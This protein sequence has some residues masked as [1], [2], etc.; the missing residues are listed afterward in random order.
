MEKKIEYIVFCGLLVLAVAAGCKKPFS[1]SL[2]ATANNYLVVEGVINS[3][4]DSTIIKLSRTVS[5]SSSMPVHAVLHAVV[6]VESDQNKSYNLTE[7]DNGR[8]VFAGL[9][10]DSTRKYRLH[11]TDGGNKEYLSDFV[12]VVN[13]PPIDTV[14]YTV[15]KDGVQI[16]TG[17]HDPK[18]ATRYY[19]WSF[20]ETWV[21]H[22]RFQSVSISDGYTVTNRPYDQNIYKCWGNDASST[23]ILGSSAKLTQDVITDKPITFV[24]AS[25]EKFTDKYS[26][27]VKQYGLTKEA[28]NFWQDLK[29]NTEQLGNIFDAQPSQLKG[30]IHA[31]NNPTELVIGYISAGAPSNKR[32]FI[33]NRQLPALTI[34]QPYPDCKM[35]TLL[36]KYFS[37]PNTTPINQVDQ[38]IN[39]KKQPIAVPLIPI[40]PIQPPGSPII[41]YSAAYPEC[42]DCTL[43]GTNIQP[44]FWK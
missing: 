9:N 14:G 2:A 26:I 7:A 38:Y 10:L 5:L 16:F 18:K 29:K 11:I 39:Y 22:S 35:D 20:D 31:V 3:G 28:Y 17:T 15:Q 41:G 23:I 19:K 27:L 6:I 1:V 24:S 12:A 44:A 4:A 36:F 43:R 32:I 8:Y 42:V 30:N 37:P 25:S 13:A 40:A 33:D 21:F 34:A